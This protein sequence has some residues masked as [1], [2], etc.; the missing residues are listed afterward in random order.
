VVT[1]NSAGIQQEHLGCSPR[2]EEV[3]YPS[4]RILDDVE[5]ESSPKRVRWILLSFI[6][7]SYRG[8]GQFGATPFRRSCIVSS[9][10]AS[11]SL[12]FFDGRTRQFASFSAAESSAAVGL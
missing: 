2:V 9:I 8:G 11:K 5:P 10:T 3:R 4:F 6:A 12:L 7:S 1:Q